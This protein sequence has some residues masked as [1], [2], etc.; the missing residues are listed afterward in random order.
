MSSIIEEITLFA[1]L[2]SLEDS[3]GNNILRRHHIFCIRLGVVMFLQPARH[4]P[5][6]WKAARMQ[7]M[8]A[9]VRLEQLSEDRLALGLCIK[10]ALLVPT[11]RLD[12]KW[13]EIA[14]LFP[15]FFYCI[16]RPDKIMRRCGKFC[17]VDSRYVGMVDVIIKLSDSGVNFIC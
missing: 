1:K 11:P 4:F 6:V 12:A 3:C 8:Q 2:W 15:H 5:L 10:N 9:K 13:S 17:P 14:K 16:W 7:R